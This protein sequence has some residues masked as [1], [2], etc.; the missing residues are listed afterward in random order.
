MEI[1]LTMELWRDN[2][3]TM[4]D[5]NLNNIYWDYA[6]F[7]L[8]CH[9][10]LCALLKAEGFRLGNT[11]NISGYC[12]RK[13][14]E[15]NKFKNTAIRMIDPFAAYY[16]REYTSSIMQ[17]VEIVKEYLLGKSTCFGIGTLG[18]LQLLAG[19]SYHTMCSCQGWLVRIFG[20]PIDCWSVS[21]RSIYKYS[22]GVYMLL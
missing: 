1:Q 21:Y 22:T 4:G 7:I 10:T 14:N 3:H 5:M 8:R 20:K 6:G 12:R 19:K 9:Q 15:S 2:G 16:Q 13:C 11:E 18:P 17:L